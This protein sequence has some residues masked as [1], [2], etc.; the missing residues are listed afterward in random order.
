[1]ARNAKLILWAL[2]Y[3][4]AVFLGGGGVWLYDRLPPGMMGC[5]VN[6]WDVTEGARGDVVE[7][8]E[9]LCDGIANSATVTLSLGVHLK[10]GQ[11]GGLRDFHLA[12][13]PHPLLALFLLFQQLS[14]PADV[15][16]VALRGDILGQR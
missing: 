5:A 6:R 3:A 8:E 10:R 16:A 9:E 13:L 14:L 2:S 4:F 11:E 1:M 7:A 15:A 12:E